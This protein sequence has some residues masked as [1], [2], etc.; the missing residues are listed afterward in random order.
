ML[1]SSNLYAMLVLPGLLKENFS[2]IDKG[3]IY[4]QRLQTSLVYFPHVDYTDMCNHLCA[5]LLLENHVEKVIATHGNESFY[6]QRSSNPNCL[7]DNL[8]NG[9]NYR[10]IFI[11]IQERCIE[12]TALNNEELDQL[13]QNSE[14]NNKIV[15]IMAGSFWIDNSII[16]PIFG[17]PT[18]RNGL[19]IFNKVAE[20]EIHTYSLIGRLETNQPTIPLTIYSFESNFTDAINT[21]WIHSRKLDI[22]KTSD[23]YFKPTPEPAGNNHTSPFENERVS[24]RKFIKETLGI[25]LDGKVSGKNNLPTL[26]I[27]ETIIKRVFDSHDRWV[28]DSRKPRMYDF[29]TSYEGYPFMS[30]FEEYKNHQANWVS[31]QAKRY[32]R[33]ANCFN[34]PNSCNQRE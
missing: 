7:L 16:Q 22:F 28:G 30:T 23:I 19:W 8:D 4:Q 27:A 31:G 2:K 3:M 29:A 33:N 5:E 15:S 25:V 18:V 11:F 26:K 14:T 32:I 6:F 13:L 1:I 24:Q 20:N 12:K 34:K 21:P 9:K 17:T 10:D